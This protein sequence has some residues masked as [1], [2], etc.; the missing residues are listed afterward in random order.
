MKKHWFFLVIAAMIVAVG[1][2]KDE[3]KATE[4]SIVAN[5]VL[6]VG[7][8]VSGMELSLV[9]GTFS[10]TYLIVDG[11]NTIKISEPESLEILGIE[12][13]ATLTIDEPKLNGEECTLRGAEPV[14]FL[15]KEANNVSWDFEVDTTKVIFITNFILPEVLSYDQLRVIILTPENEELPYYVREGVDTISVSGQ[16]AFD[17][18]NNTIQ[19]GGKILGANINGN[20]NCFPYCQNHQYGY[21]FVTVEP[22]NNVEWVFVLPN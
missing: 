6:P 12:A 4:V 8:T 1:C 7:V 19:I 18:L 17:L 13:T 5:T 16:V 11:Q 20:T 9:A 2:S 22:V 15:V 10:Q 14:N 3:E 21:A